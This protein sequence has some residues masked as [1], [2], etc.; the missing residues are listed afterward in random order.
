[1]AAVV[2]SRPQSAANTQTYLHI[3][4]AADLSHLDTALL[5][6]TEEGLPATPDEKA[7]Q[8]SQ[9]WMIDS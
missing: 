5:P 7:H 4:T 9:R 1:M 3:N 8:W 6:Q 2:H